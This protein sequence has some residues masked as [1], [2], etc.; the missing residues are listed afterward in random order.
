MLMF[1]RM[2]LA[3]IAHQ[4]DVPLAAGAG[5]HLDYAEAQRRSGP[6]LGRPIPDVPGVVQ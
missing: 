3:A 1:D 6:R 2:P 4:Y 5:W